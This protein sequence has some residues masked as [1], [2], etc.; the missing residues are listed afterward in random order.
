MDKSENTTIE[1]IKY[2]DQSH[3]ICVCFKAKVESNI[4]MNYN[5][6]L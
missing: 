1:T 3:Q 6:S 2:P 5:D 4:Q